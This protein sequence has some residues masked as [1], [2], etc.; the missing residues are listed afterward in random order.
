MLTEFSRRLLDWYSIHARQLPWRTLPFDFQ[1]DNFQSLGIKPDPYRVW[2]SEIMLQQ[3][4]VETIL[5]YF[6]NWLNHFPTLDTLA[7]ASEQE[8]LSVW[9]GLGYYSRARNFHKAAQKVIHE[10]DGQIPSKRQVLEKLP[11]IGRY[12]AAAISS[13]AFGEDEPALDGNIRRVLARFFNMQMPT[14][15]PAGEKELWNLAAAQLPSGRAGDY[16]QAIMDL[17]ATICTPRG[18]LCDRCP[19][20]GLCQAERLGL[21]KELP[22]LEIHQPV[23]PPDRHG[24]YPRTRGSGINRPAPIQRPPRGIMGISGWKTKRR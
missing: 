5:P 2:V 16:N 12:T 21:Q 23:P 18:P 24:C 17:G 7:K 14:H 9:E 1:G 3:T 22:I 10:Y 20:R 19:L 4:R 6:Q 13:I 15:S 11:G 8:V